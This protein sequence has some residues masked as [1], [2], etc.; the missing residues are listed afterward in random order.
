MSVCSVVTVGTALGAAPT[1]R[2]QTDT[3]TPTTQDYCNALLHIVTVELP[4]GSD[5]TQPAVESAFAQICRQ[6][7]VPCQAA[8]SRTLVGDRL[9]VSVPPATLMDMVA[10]DAIRT[11]CDRIGVYVA[12]R[13]VPKKQPDPKQG[14]DDP[15]KS[16]WTGSVLSTTEMVKLI[17]TD[18]SLVSTKAFQD[19]RIEI[20]IYATKHGQGGG[21]PSR[22]RSRTLSVPSLPAGKPRSLTGITCRLSHTDEVYRQLDGKRVTR[23]NGDKHYG[24]VVEVYMG[25]TLIKSAASSRGLVQHPKP[26]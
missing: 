6:V 13:V 12:L 7:G 10:A 18:V 22:S 9:T 26:D 3:A 19:L 25:K 20:H 5:G 8:I 17:G 11:L 16:S 4:A 1:A 15:H 14:H 24:W 21:K 2:E 23:R